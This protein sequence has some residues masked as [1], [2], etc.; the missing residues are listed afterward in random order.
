MHVDTETIK[1]LAELNLQFYQTLARPFAATRQRLQPGVKRLLSVLQPGW[2]LLDLGCGNGELWRAL[3][4]A[5]HSGSYVGLDFSPEMLRAAAEADPAERVLTENARPVQ[6]CAPQT[7][8]PA[9]IWL[10]A[11]LTAPDWELPLADRRFEAVLAF[12]V[13]HH[14]PGKHLRLQ[15]LKKARRLLAPGGRFIHSEWQFLNSPRL[16][17]RILPWETLGLT[18]SQVDTGDYLLDWRHG[19]YGLRYVHHFSEAELAQLAAESGFAVIETFFSDGEGGKLGLYQTW[20]RR[21]T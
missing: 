11:D 9:T 19:G 5:G 17:G 14:L 3:K 16:R 15:A 6:P 18:G 10:Q 1:R 21:S 8:P 4:R 20:E 2:Q 12:A 13:L 7:A